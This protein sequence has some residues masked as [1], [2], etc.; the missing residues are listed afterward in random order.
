MNRKRR[1]SGRDYHERIPTAEDANMIDSTGHRGGYGDQR[2]AWAGI[3]DNFRG[4]QD[5]VAK[6]GFEQ[7]LEWLAD[8]ARRGHLRI[9]D[10]HEL[11]GELAELAADEGYVAWRNYQRKAFEAW[12]SPLDPNFAGFSCPGDLC[13]RRA[14]PSS[15]APPRCELLR[16]AMTDLGSDGSGQGR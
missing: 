13:S 7:R 5:R 16:R 11:L 10:W 4:L 9:A 8:Q 15:G 14:G 6:Y 3:C 2:T 12:P 1:I